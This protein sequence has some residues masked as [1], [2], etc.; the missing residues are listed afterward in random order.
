MFQYSCQEAQDGAKNNFSNMFSM[1][2]LYM[3]HT[4]FIES[5][6]KVSLLHECNVAEMSCVTLAQAIS[7]FKCPLSG[8]YHAYLGSCLIAG[9]NDLIIPH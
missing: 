9:F 1:L 8:K 7:V 4:K 6:R 3:T 2:I 5:A